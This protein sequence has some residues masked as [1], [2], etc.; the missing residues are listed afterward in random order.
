[1]CGR[2]GKI[3]LIPWLAAALRG[4]TKASPAI[5]PH[6]ARNNT[7]TSDDS[8]KGAGGAIHCS[9]LSVLAITDSLLQGNAAPFASGGAVSYAGGFSIAVT[10]STVD[11]NAASICAAV[12][13]MAAT[14][15]VID[16]SDVTNNTAALGDAGGVGF[17][18]A[19]LAQRLQTCIGAELSAA[20]ITDPY[21]DLSVVS[22]DAFLPLS[23][24]ECTWSVEPQDNCI[25]ELT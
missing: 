19:P 14:S 5:S 22:L 25:T 24:F 11:A 21:G 15:V 17:I 3:S 2:G 23:D 16:G 7:A 20:T 8:L 4:R 9:F 13:I 18:E 1:M 6:P 10:N 12:C